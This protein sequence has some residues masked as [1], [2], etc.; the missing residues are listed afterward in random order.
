M[1]PFDTARLLDDVGWK[2]VEVLQ[3][4]GRI[5]FAELGRRVGL[6]TPAVTERVRRLEEAGI[7]TGYHAAVDT[8]RLGY[9]IMAL[10]RLAVTGDQSTRVAKMLMAIPEVVECHHVTGADCYVCTLLACS[11]PHL[12]ALIDQLAQ[13]GSTTTSLVMST[14]IQRRIVSLP[15]PAI[16]ARYD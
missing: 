3:A 4:E 11:I 12:E 1:N 7:I 5:S 15:Q 14:P 2:I 9:P 13:F 10:V 8:T 16:P 6:S